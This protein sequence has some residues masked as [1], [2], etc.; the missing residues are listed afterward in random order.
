MQVHLFG[1][2]GS[3]P[4]PG[5]DTLRY[6]GNTSCVGISNDGELPS[7]LLDFG[8]GARNFCR[9][10]GDRPF[11]GTVLL[12]HLHW[13]HILGLPFFPPADMPG[14]QVAVHLPAQGDPIAALERPMSPP[15]FPIGPTG[16]RGDW[17]F[18]GLETGVH[19]FEGFRVLAREIPHGGG[20]TFGYRIDDGTHS[21]A[22]LSD[23][24]PT[25]MGHGPDGIGAYHE[26][27]VELAGEVDMLIH[28]SQY[29]REEFALRSSWGHCVWEYP[30]A[31]GN[32]AG[33][34]RVVLTHHEPGHSDAFLDDI[35]R[36]L[37][38]NASLA[39]EES[40]LT[41]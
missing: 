9:S 18:N 37:P 29:T 26:T 22:Y 11:R 20:R 41:V 17:S 5:P 19:E 23:H 35:A 27:A 15:A 21:V 4:T 16:L 33:A 10:L 36:K 2:R 25:A 14:A 12:G 32:A 6:G 7:L 1:V 31:L 13:D 40:V 34:R 28:D 38:K 39:V 30:I 3:I 8:T 24:C